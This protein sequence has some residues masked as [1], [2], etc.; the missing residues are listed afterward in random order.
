M[1]FDGAALAL[2]VLALAAVFVT[3]AIKVVPQQHAWVVERLGR[4]DRTLAPGL[5]FLIPF[6][7]RVTYQHSLKEIPMDV[8]SQVCITRDNT[9][10]T[11]RRRPVLPGHRCD[12]RFV[13]I[14][15]LRGRDHPACADHAALGDRQARARPDLRGARRHQRQRRRGAG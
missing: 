14:E 15:Q 3:R 6:I 9:Q 10:L 1:M 12:A 8:P 7:E 4:Y 5:N 13:R 11:R 2:V